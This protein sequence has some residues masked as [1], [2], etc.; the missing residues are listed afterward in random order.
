MRNEINCAISSNTVIQNRGSATIH[1]GATPSGARCLLGGHLRERGP[2]QVAAGFSM[3]WT[4]KLYM[5]ILS[6]PLGGANHTAL[7]IFKQ[8]SNAVLV[9]HRGEGL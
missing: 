6:W 7:L 4:K 1:L 2:C 5:Q 9:V 8:M 3:L